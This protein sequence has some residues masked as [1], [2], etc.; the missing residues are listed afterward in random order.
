MTRLLLICCAI[1]SAA[2]AGDGADSGGSA[3]AAETVP[4][5][6]ADTGLIRGTPPGGLADWVGEIE[7]GIG[8]IAER[9]ARDR[10]GARKAALDLYVGRQEYLEMYYGTNGRLS[11][12]APALG[13][14]V[15]AAEARFHDLMML[16]NAPASDSAATVSAEAALLESYR[17][18]RDEATEANVAPMPPGNAPASGTG[19]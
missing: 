16:L 3:A 11:L 9:A 14:A 12:E 17:A 6:V 7:A 19:S 2:C 1:G 4:P 5:A 18:V 10:A 8:G 15:M 13:E